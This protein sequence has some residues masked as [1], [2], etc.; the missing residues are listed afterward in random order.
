MDRIQQVSFERSGWLS[1]EDQANST[2]YFVYESVCV[3]VHE[4]SFLSVHCL[5]LL[6]IESEDINLLLK[7][8]TL[9]LCT[10]CLAAF[11][12]IPQLTTQANIYII[13][14]CLWYFCTNRLSSFYMGQ[15]CAKLLCLNLNHRIWFN[16]DKEIAGTIQMSSHKNMQQWL[17][18]FFSLK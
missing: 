18:L 6:P 11:T 15:S 14:D 17:S 16:R 2:P 1:S 9:N 8:N 10:G 13:S 12:R 3:I 4:P 5:V 7:V